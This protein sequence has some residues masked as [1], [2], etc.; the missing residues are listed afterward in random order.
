MV[1]LHVGFSVDE[2]WLGQLEAL[3]MLMAGGPIDAR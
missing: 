1:G 3:G 2:E